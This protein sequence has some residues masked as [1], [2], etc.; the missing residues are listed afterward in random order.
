M[1]TC[2]H[3]IRDALKDVCDTVGLPARLERGKVRGYLHMISTVGQ[4]CDGLQSENHTKTTG[5]SKTCKITL[6]KYL[7]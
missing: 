6:I 4:R 1:L 3:R 2:T 5:K 7:F